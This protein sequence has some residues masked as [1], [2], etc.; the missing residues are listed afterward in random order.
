M[1]AVIKR[2]AQLEGRFTP[3]VQPDFLRNPPQRFRVVVSGRAIPGEP[4]ARRPG[5]CPPPANARDR[6]PVALVAVTRTLRN[7]RPD[8]FSALISPRRS[9]RKPVVRQ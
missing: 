2:I 6:A 4:M 3:K 5:E 1:K 8:R 7:N 9:G